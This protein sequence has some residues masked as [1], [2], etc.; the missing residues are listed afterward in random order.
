MEICERWENAPHDRL[1]PRVD[2]SATAYFERCYDSV[3]D[4]VNRSTFEHR[5]RHHFRTI[6]SG[7]KDEDAAWYALRNIVYAAG[8]RC[9]LANDGSVS[10]LEAQWQAFS[11]FQNALSVFNELIFAYTGLTGVRVL[12]I[13]V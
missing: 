9:A 1:T 5:L 13:M 7:Q 11:C 8:C 6:Q 12:T 10:F 2:S 3:F 4:I